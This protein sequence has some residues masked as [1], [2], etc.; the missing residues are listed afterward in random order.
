[1]HPQIA[2]RALL[3][4]ALFVPLLTLIA[5]ERNASV[6][7]GDIVGSAAGIVFQLTAILACWAYNARR[8]RTLPL[9]ARYCWD[10]LVHTLRAVQRDPVYEVLQFAVTVASIASG[11]AYAYNLV[12]ARKAGALGYFPYLLA[13]N[14]SA[15]GAF[16]LQGP[17]GESLGWFRTDF[18][19]L[20][21][22]SGLEHFAA[23]AIACDFSA[24]LLVAKSTCAFVTDFYNVVDF[25]SCVF[26]IYGFLL[27]A[28]VSPTRAYHE[29]LLQA[30][31][32]II[33][34]RR[35]P[36]LLDQSRAG[37]VSE[38]GAF[39]IQP[40]LASAWRCEPTAASSTT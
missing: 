21:W 1:M 8:R 10:W 37:H 36:R 31:F 26:V 16:A 13:A 15:P 24:R 29:V 28:T 38:V 33:R 5:G 11:V 9:S 17:A 22:H 30:P 18:A 23:V 27:N 3:I 39:A 32:R 35:L 7:L 20:G 4:A 34:L 2:L 6:R 19:S 25:L 12:V 40:V 14:A